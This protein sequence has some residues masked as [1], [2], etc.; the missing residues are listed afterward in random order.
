MTFK[1][2]TKDGTVVVVDKV[3]LDLITAFLVLQGY[4]PISVEIT[5]MPA[6]SLVDQEADSADKITGMLD[7][8]L[9]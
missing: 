4:P 5:D 3:D 6:P 9:A 7:R 2:T 1:I 8:K